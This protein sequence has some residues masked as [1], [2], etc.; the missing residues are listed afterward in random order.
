M[1]WRPASQK[2]EKKRE[3]GE[4]CWVEVLDESTIDRP[5]LLCVSWQSN[6]GL[7]TTAQTCTVFES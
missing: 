2:K 1:V 7:D 3:K 5:G 6:L 4:G